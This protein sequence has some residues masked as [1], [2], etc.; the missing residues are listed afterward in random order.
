M[1]V[2]KNRDIIKKLFDDIAIRFKDR[3]GG[4]TRMYLLDTRPGDNAKWLSL[5]LVERVKRS[6]RGEREQERQEIVIPYM[7]IKKGGCMITVAF[8]FCLPRIISV[9]YL[10]AQFSVSH[11]CK[12]G[13]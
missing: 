2:I 11:C 3:K 13:S 8:L 9:Q 10:F 6:A 4:Y 7:D 1:K 12:A 5:E